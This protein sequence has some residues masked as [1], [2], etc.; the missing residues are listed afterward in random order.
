MY[1]VDEAKCT[2]CETCV[3]ACP[4]EAIS[5]VGGKARID[6]DLCLECGSCESECPNGA[7]SEV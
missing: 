3:D 7:I 6:P 5:M 2:G 1:K 4:N